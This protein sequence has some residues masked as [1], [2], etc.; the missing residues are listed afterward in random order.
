[1]GLEPNSMEI[2]H[3]VTRWTITL[4]MY[5]VKS[6]YFTYYVYIFFMFLYLFIFYQPE[7]DGIDG[8]ME[9]YRQTIKNV[10]LDGPTNFSP[11]IFGLFWLSKKR[12]LILI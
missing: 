11:V 8:V 9:V 5:V 3:T 6:I 10:E 12:T 1:M 7:V 2:Y 4:K